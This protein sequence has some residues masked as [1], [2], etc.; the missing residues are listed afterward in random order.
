MKRKLIILL[1]CVF[2][3]LCYQ[4]NFIPHE[5]PCHIDIYSKNDLPNKYIAYVS[6]TPTFQ[7]Q[8]L[9]ESMIFISEQKDLGTYGFYDIHAT[10]KGNIVKIHIDRQWANNDAEAR[11]TT[12]YAIISSPHNIPINRI[13]LYYDSVL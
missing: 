13:A 7:V 12:Y 9:S 2:L 8:K 5:T 3:F 11:G 6:D 1:C 10:M 4:V